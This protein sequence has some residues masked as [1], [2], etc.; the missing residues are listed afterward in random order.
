VY[1]LI[2]TDGG[3]SGAGALG[4]EEISRRRSREAKEAVAALGEEVELLELVLP[5]GL[6]SHEELVGLLGDTLIRL[7]AGIV[8]TTS[9]V[10]FHPEHVRVGAAVAE[11]FV[12]TRGRNGCR[13]VRAYEVQVPLTPLL[14]NI[15]AD[16]SDVIHRKRRALQAYETQLPALPWV[17][18]QERYLRAVYGRKRAVEAFW[19]MRPD[20]FCRVMRHEH[21]RAHHVSPYR[22][23]RLRPFT[24][25]LAW[26]VGTCGRRRLRRLTTS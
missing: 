5:E 13:V 21:N 24:D 20:V 23:L 12:A 2:V 16:V 7:K 4:R 18:R 11:A 19:Q 3:S 26:L 14:A 1:V 9:C 8:Y 25:G 22:S 17:P 6:W 10:D 15:I